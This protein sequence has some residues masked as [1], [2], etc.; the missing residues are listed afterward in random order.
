MA[1]PSLKKLVEELNSLIT[2]FKFMEALD[3]FYDKEVVTHE[4]ENLPTIG[5]DAYKQSGLRF[6]DSISNQSAKLKN[7]IV[8]DDMSVT[9]WHYVF[10]HNVW[11]HWDYVQLSLQK[12]R[13]GKIIFERHHYNR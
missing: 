3:K 8:S 12:W 9:E 7:V 6:L 10:D 2:E 5:L 11:G 4:N 13:N 1:T